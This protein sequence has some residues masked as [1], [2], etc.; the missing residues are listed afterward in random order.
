[1]QALDEAEINSP[2]RDLEEM[3]RELAEEQAKNKKLMANLNNQYCKISRLRK[4]YYDQLQKAENEH[5]RANQAK[6]QL[7]EEKKLLQESNQAKD[8]QIML[9][10]GQL[11]VYKDELQASKS[12]ANY[13]EKLASERDR[14]MGTLKGELKAIETK[15]SNLILIAWNTHSPT[16]SGVASSFT[17]IYFKLCSKFIRCNFFYINI[18]LQL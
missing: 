12:D 7:L 1:M 8:E 9:L 11:Q 3:T 13:F 2:S 4:T 5:F 18:K 6:Q 15:L 14:A 16:N 17:V 10:S